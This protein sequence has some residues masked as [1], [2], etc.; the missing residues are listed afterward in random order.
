[1]VC[2][3]PLCFEYVRSLWATLKKKSRAFTSV[4][5]HLGILK[6]T[7]V[8]LSGSWPIFPR[9]RASPVGR[10]YRQPPVGSL[11]L[12]L[13]CVSLFFYFLFFWSTMR[14]CSF[15]CVFVCMFIEPQTELC[16]PRERHSCKYW[17]IFNVHVSADHHLEMLSSLFVRVFFF[18]SFLARLARFRSC[19][20]F[21][22][23]VFRFCCRRAWCVIFRLV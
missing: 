9:L 5:V 6:S 17:C 2:T 21:V 18:S 23:S 14:R 20:S 11:L 22:F 19:C 15:V 13:H 16:Y 8:A 10:T 12:Y 4:S 1:M 3:R 7:V